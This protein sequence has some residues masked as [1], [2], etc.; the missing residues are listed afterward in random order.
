MTEYQRQ[1]IEMHL[2]GT[3]MNKI[4]LTHVAIMNKFSVGHIYTILHWHLKGWIAQFEDKERIAYISTRMDED[5]N[6]LARTL[7]IHK[8]RVAAIKGYLGGNGKLN[9]RV[10]RIVSKEGQRFSIRCQHCKGVSSRESPSDSC[11]YCG[12]TN[13]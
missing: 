10:A 3:S 13:V 4:A 2:N 9:Q 11:S 6:S 1:I 7:A 8:N 5:N 12:K